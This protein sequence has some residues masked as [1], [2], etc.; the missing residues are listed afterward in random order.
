MANEKMEVA[1]ASQADLA[2]DM[3]KHRQTYG[4]FFRIIAYS[5]AGLAI[6]LLILFLA[7]GERGTYLA[8]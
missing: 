4:S 5:I 6:L 2:A 3:E 8:P 1:R 7:L